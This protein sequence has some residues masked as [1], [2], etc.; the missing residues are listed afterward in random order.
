ML[1]V[2][3]VALLTVLA[4]C[5]LGFAGLCMQDYACRTMHAGGTFV[6][7]LCVLSLLLLYTRWVHLLLFITPNLPGGCYRCVILQLAVS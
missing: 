5:K 7:I 4:A 6:R 3:R 1:Y 2:L